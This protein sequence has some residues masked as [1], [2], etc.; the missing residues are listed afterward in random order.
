[1]PDKFRP[2]MS[3]CMNPQAHAQGWRKYLLTGRK[4]QRVEMK[5]CRFTTGRVTAAKT[6]CVSQKHHDCYEYSGRVLRLVD[7]K[8]FLIGKMMMMVRQQVAV[9]VSKSCLT[10]R[11]QWSILSRG[12]QL[13]MP[14]CIICTANASRS[15]S[16]FTSDQ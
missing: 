3:A 8:T 7:N 14:Y 15:F 1:M 5:S 6:R 13:F 16:L 12:K 9:P 4:H 2:L 11:P 10:L